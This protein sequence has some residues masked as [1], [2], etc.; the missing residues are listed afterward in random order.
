MSRLNLSD[1]TLSWVTIRVDFFGTLYAS[2]LAIYLTYL[3]HMSASNAGF[4]LNMASELRIQSVVTAIEQ[5]G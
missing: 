5:L 3:A 1:Q 2:G 4:S